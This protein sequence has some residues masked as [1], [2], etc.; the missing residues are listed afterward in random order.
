MN[1]E[2]LKR[3]ICRST[4]WGFGFG[5]ATGL[6]VLAV[7][8]YR[9]RPKA[10]DTRS[11]KA[12]SAKAEGIGHVRDEKGS[13]TVDTVGT[14]FTVDIE[15]T[16][17][18]DLTLRHDL[19]VMEA[20]RGSGALHESTLKLPKDY[21][22]P[23]HHTVTISLDADDLCTVDTNTQKCFDRSFGDESTILIFDQ[24]A[25][26]EIRIPMPVFI[27]EKDGAPRFLDPTIGP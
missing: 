10:W 4:A 15:N 18:L 27:P 24:A 8:A 3:F 13:L 5:M 20:T 23:A 17:G 19:R 6:M 9:G 26:F 2:S 1:K 25:K 22:L 11:L 14:T 16:T 7:V 21:F 12:T